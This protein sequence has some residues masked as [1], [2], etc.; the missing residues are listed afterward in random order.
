MMTTV[1]KRFTAFKVLRYRKF[2]LLWSGQV[3]SALGDGMYRIALAR[4]VFVLTKS[5]AWMGAVLVFYLVPYV[6]LSLFGGVIADR[7]QHQRSLILLGSDI[8]RAIIVALI[9]ML[10]WLQIVQLWHVLLLWFLF[11]V[12]DAFFRPA[13]SALRPQLVD[14]DIFQQA[15]A[16]TSLGL[17]MS[18]VLGP[19]LGALCIAL[20][21]IASVFALDAVSFLVSVCS[22]VA[23]HHLFSPLAPVENTSEE[24][25]FDT[26]SVGR[27]PL[28]RLFNEIGEGFRYVFH[29]PFLWISIVIASVGNVF[30]FG[31][32]TVILPKLIYGAYAGNNW[33]LSLLLAADAGGALLASL[34]FMQYIPHRGKRGLV[35]Y[36]WLAVCCIGFLLLGLPLTPAAIP[37]VLTFGL[38]CSGF[39]LTGAIIF[40]ETLVQEHVP[41][42]IMGRVMSVDECGSA[43][44][45]PIGVAI[46]GFA[47]DH[48]GPA[49]IFLVIGVLWL[50]MIGSALS[51]RSIRSVA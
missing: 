19:L 34:F 6:L 27:N 4:E 44:A 30:Y 7:L 41:E 31:A 17:N 47:A 36:C 29:R 24:Y 51:T 2:A 3:I 11:G 12:A 48:S 45:L 42:E 22:L 18:S 26:L 50:I 13:Y 9:A 28:Q 32:V 23:L 25:A 15:N 14:D 46:L 38:A 35:M 49:T 37:Y 16:T 40:W 10:I 43:L 5:A 1:A 39:G 21:G 8:G 20:V 33:L